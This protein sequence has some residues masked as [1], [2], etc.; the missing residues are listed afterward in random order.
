[1]LIEKKEWTTKH[2]ELQESL[3]EVQEVLKCE[4]A[5]NLMA[6]SQVEER[7][8]NL[9]KALDAERQCVAQLERAL[10]ESHG[11]LDIIKMTSD[12]KLADANHLVAG[13]QDRSLE[14]QQKL[15]AA[16]AKLAEASRKSLEMERK[17]QEVETR[18]S[19]FKRERMSFIPN[20]TQDFS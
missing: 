11:E 15:F 16:D 13:I 6:V 7:E 8:I 3:L 14:V 20:L 9:R 17:L 2:E 5:A 1:M 12:T 18:E 4:K 19:L 10:L